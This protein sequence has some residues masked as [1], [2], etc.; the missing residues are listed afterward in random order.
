V[1]PLAFLFG[2]GA[3]MVLQSSTA[4]ILLVASFVGK[5]YVALYVCI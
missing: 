4:A 3:S 2:A 1:R 5:G